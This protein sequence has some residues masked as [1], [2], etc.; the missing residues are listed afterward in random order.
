MEER[1]V[2]VPEGV[3]I[4]IEGDTLAG[5]T[6]RASGPKGENSRFLKYRGIHIEKTED[7]RIRVYTTDKKSKVRAMVG[8]FASHINNLIKGVTEGFEYRLKILYSHFPMKV[9]VEGDEV[10]IENFLGEKHPRRAK[11]FGRCQVK[12]SG[13]EII[14]TGID[15]EECGQTAANLELATKKKNLDVRIF[16]DGIY[17]VEKP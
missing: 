8:T 12:V 10:I 16:Q 1:F 5:F 17:I 4:E 6:I 15:K 3:S 2:N 9:R 11:I 7:G 14:V 13:N